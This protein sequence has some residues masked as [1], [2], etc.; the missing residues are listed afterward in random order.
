MLQK[1]PIL[2]SVVKSL[3]F[4]WYFKESHFKKEL[5][6]IWSNEWIYGCHEDNIKEPLS[7]ITLQIAQFNII[8]LRSKDGEVCSYLN[9]CNHRGSTLCKDSQGKLKNQV[10]NFHILHNR[11]LNSPLECDHKI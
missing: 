10:R 11:G 5:N 9:T 7:Y 4:N 1:S 8:I 6:K 2:K 3:P